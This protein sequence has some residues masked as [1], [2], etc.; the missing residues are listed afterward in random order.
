MYDATQ[1]MTDI[2]EKDLRTYLCRGYSHLAS[3]LE[4]C[5]GINELLDMLAKECSL[6]DVSLLEAV[7]DRFKIPPA[8]EAIQKYK[9]EVDE[10]CEKTLLTECLNK[11][12]S[13]GSLLE[14]EK[15]TINV[16]G[17]AKEHRFKDVKELT[18]YAFGKF[19]SHVKI[20]I[21]E[22]K[23]S[24]TV[25]CSF[26]LILSE[27]LI[28]SVLENLEILKTKGLLQLTIGHGIVYDAVIYKYKHY[29]IIM[30]L[31]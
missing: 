20:I 2:S 11:K 28:A 6:T 16:R 1:A 5:N 9:K 15:I 27:S 3:K 13:S 22:V 21:I 30:N 4:K 8:T 14:S 12:I 10:F 26:P 25:T 29:N 18:Q 17:L 7:A 31:K 23:N 19:K 24:F